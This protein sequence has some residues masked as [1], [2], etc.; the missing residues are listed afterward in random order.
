MCER[1][2]F[3]SF[4][5]NFPSGSF[6]SRLSSVRSLFIG[7][8][9]HSPRYLLNLLRNIM[10]IFVFMFHMRIY[11]ND[12]RIYELIHIE[13]TVYGNTIFYSNNIIFGNTHS[14]NKH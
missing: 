3:F 5:V 14:R 2:R 7:L 9:C 1:M 8:K 6:S 4:K 12:V 11:T 10:S 13:Y